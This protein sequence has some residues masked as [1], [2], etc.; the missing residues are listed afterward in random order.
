VWFGQV[1]A[2]DDPKFQRPP[3]DVAT[4]SLEPEIN[5]SD[6]F[7][8]KVSELGKSVTTQELANEA[9][10]KLSNMAIDRSGQR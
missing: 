9:A 7:S 10:I 5:M 1:A 3:A 4:W 6:Q 8:W 2:P